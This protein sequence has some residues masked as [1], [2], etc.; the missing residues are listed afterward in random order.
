MPKLVVLSET[1]TYPVCVGRKTY[2]R[3]K[4]ILRYYGKICK[5]QKTI[6]V[7]GERYNII[8]IKNVCEMGLIPGFSKTITIER[9]KS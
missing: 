1:E 5:N 8:E 6:I 4:M 9:F 2:T 7:N 3:V